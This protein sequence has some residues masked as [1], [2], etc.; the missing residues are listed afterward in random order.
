MVV[1]GRYRTPGKATAKLTGRIGEEPQEHAFDVKFVKR[2]KDGRFAFIEK[3]WAT[4]RVGQ[5]INELD[6]MEGDAGRDELI[7]ELVAL[8]TKHGIMTPYTSFLADE[9]TR[10]GDLA[11]NRAAAGRQLRMLEEAEGLGGFNQR[12]Q[13]NSLLFAKNAYQNN[14]AN[15]LQQQL[16][17]YGGGIGGGGSGGGG[18]PGVDLSKLPAFGQVNG[19]A[20]K[21]L[22][23]EP[24]RVE[25][26][27][28]DTLYRRGDLVVTPETEGLDV[29]KD[30]ADITK[31]TRF[32]DA[33]F[34]LVAANSAAENALLSRQRDGE[35]LLVNLRG[36][37]YLI[38]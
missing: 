38:E 18:A 8:A 33:Y 20:S 29:E 9:T 15:D 30:A 21:P 13:K 24:S 12:G 1:V 11:G 3:L 25:S 6:L 5:I 28:K 22:P 4:R 10:F 32:S 7:D 23:P 36:T 27:G 2:S 35:R 31:L 17:R 37:N 34:A 19:G 26:A 14:A 16:G